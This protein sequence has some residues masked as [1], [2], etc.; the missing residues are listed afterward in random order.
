MVQI[1]TKRCPQSSQQ[2]LLVSRMS[3]PPD[4]PGFPGLITKAAHNFRKA[5]QVFPPPGVGLGVGIGVGCGFGWS[6]R[7]AYGPPRALCG[8]AIAAGVGFGYGQG[9][10]RRFGK[11]VR[12]KSFLDWVHRLEA[13]LD[14]CFVAV[15]AFLSLQRKKLTRS[16]AKQD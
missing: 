6:L 4:L 2:L 11:D 12:S 9:F 16:P 5:T 8:P 3:E 7:R 14:E 15:V 10:G 13:T 1:E